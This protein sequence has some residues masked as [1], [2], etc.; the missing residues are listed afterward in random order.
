MFYS[1]LSKGNTKLV[2]LKR[3]AS[4][5]PGCYSGVNDFFYIDK[6]TRNEF[7]IEEEYLTPLIRSSDDID[8]LYVKLRDDNFVLTIDSIPEH[9][10]KPNVRKY[11]KWGE[12]QVTRKRQ[13]TAEGLL[14]PK[15]ES[16]KNR[17]FWYSIPPK[18]LIP[19]NLFMQY[20]ANNRFYCPFS[21]TTFVSDRCFHR[22]FV[23]N[24]EYL[25]RMTLILNSTFQLFLVMLFG[26]SN[27]GLGALKFEAKDANNLLTLHPSN[28]SNSSIELLFSNILKH[29]PVDV[30]QECGLDPESEIPI[31]EQEPK[32]LPD[33][34]E[35]DDIVFDAL[36]LTPDERKEVYRAV[37]QLVWNRISK[38]KSVKKR[39]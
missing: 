12:K 9:K 8:S 27:L 2:K 38:A 14:W 19:T 28:L 37:C 30:F 26:R 32:P 21:E 4:A 16:V 6:K 20:V 39:K 5:L 15:T 11:I 31:S 34:K 17:R 1:I 29:T 18:N 24:K 3:I 10:L 7:K 33:R 36:D 35:L 23:E 25:K 13:K 22:I